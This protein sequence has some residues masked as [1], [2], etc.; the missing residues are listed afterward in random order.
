M[1][2]T[3]LNEHRVYTDNLYAKV[4]DTK[5]KEIVGEMKEINNAFKHNHQGK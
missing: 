3:L 2:R 1:K 5:T 4:S